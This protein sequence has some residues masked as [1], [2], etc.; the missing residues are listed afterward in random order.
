MTENKIINVGP[1]TSFN[2]L[3]YYLS[4]QFLE[5]R[6]DYFH[7]RRPKIQFDFS[8]VRSENISLAALAALLAVGKKIRDFIGYPIPIISDWKP[9]VNSFLTDCHFIEVANKLKIFDFP[10]EMLGTIR[11]NDERGNPS[12]RIIYFGDVKSIENIPVDQVGIEK[13]K[14]KQKIFGNLKLRFSSIFQNFD[15]EH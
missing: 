8:Q 12:T 9:K 1:L 3:V 10:L 13:A 15:N 11:L 14:H 7:G 2:S 6:N 5:I 4:N